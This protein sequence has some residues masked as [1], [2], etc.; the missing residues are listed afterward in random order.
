M[1]VIFCDFFFFFFLP[2]TRKA[3]SAAPK[4]STKPLAE[5]WFAVFA[6]QLA[7]KTSKIPKGIPV[8]IFKGFC[9]VLAA[10]CP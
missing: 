5:R 6:E 9:A 7:V 2:Y 10:N 4:I 1:K 3:A 8:G